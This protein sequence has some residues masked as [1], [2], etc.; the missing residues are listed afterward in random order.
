MGKNDN[1]RDSKKINRIGSSHSPKE[2]KA[3][4]ALTEVGKVQGAS[5]VK[6]VT[7]VGGVR[8]ADAAGA[9]SFEQRE[10]LMKIVTEEAEKLAAQGV[11]SNQ[12]RAVIEN[13]VKLAIDAALVDEPPPPKR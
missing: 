3:T 2:V 1:D 9:V 4:E 6:R 12:Q 10:R 5:E 13:A 8:R 11:L 7:G